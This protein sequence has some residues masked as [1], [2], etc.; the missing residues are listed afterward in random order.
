MATETVHVR[1]AMTETTY[2][3]EGQEY[4]AVKAT[5]NEISEYHGLRS[6]HTC[7]IPHFTSSIVL[8]FSRTSSK[9]LITAK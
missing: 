7:I 9:I 3:L 2:R 4:A 1:V 5:G 8:N 6:E